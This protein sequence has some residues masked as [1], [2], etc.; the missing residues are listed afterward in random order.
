MTPRAGHLKTSRWEVAPADPQAEALARPL[1]GS[2][3]LGQVLANRGLTD[4]QQAIGFLEARLADLHDPAMLPNCDDAARKIV[5]AVRAKKRIVIYGDYDVDGMTATAILQAALKLAGANVDF[6]VPHRLEEGYG[7]NAAAIEKL[8]AEGAEMII[9]VDCGVSD[10]ES[11]ARACA[12]GIEVIVTD[13][14]AILADPPEVSAVVHPALPG[15]NY[16]CNYLCGA[17]VAFK[18]AWEIAR[19]LNDGEKSQGPMREFLL[20]ATC[21]AGLGTIADVVPLLGENRIL[22][23]HALLALPA[24]KHIGLCALRRIAGLDEKREISARDI[25]FGVA[26]RLNAAGRMGHARDAIELLA[27][28]DPARAAELAGLLESLNRKRKATEKEI[29]E[30]AIERVGETKQDTDDCRAIVL[31]EGDWHGGVIGIVANRL[32]DKFNKPAILIALDE[33]GNGQGSCRTIETFHITNALSACSEHLLGFGGHAMAGGFR[34]A[35]GAIEPFT[36]AM[37]AYAKTHLN[38][39]PIESVLP[40]DA[41]VTLAELSFPVVDQLRRLAPFGRENPEPTVLIQNA[42]LVRPAKRIGQRGTTVD[43][44]IE[45][46]GA[47]MRCIGF[48]MGDLA[49]ELRGATHIDLV[50]APTINHFNR[51]TTA[52][53]QIQDARPAKSED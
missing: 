25:A 42:R 18:L 28:S 13:H 46:D 14:H 6:Y 47:A 32:V 7:V 31:A 45:Q 1:G 2:R 21:L 41:A 12:A 26:P 23:K 20:N 53:L 10:H 11:L 22:A 49:D 19:F 29:T 43:M 16:P 36:A 9:T 51:R 38:D 24:T 44:M 37:H 52:E 33:E 5:A 27:T 8:I 30:H 35:P 15:T 4:A 17:G 34:I 3:L 39:E 48:R 40:I 50:G